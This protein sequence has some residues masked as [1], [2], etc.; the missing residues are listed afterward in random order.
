MTSE[1]NLSPLPQKELDVLLIC[2]NYISEVLITDAIVYPMNLLYLAAYVREKGIEVD[3]LDGRA[4]NYSLADYREYLIRRRPKI[5]G[6]TVMTSYV[7][8]AV[9][10]AELAKSISDDIVVIVG[11]AHISAL[12]AESLKSYGCFDIAVV[13][14]GEQTLLE[15]SRKVLNH[16]FDFSGV[17]GI[18]YRQKGNIKATKPRALF[19]DLDS[20]PYPA[21]DLLP[22]DR[23]RPS[24]QW[25]KKR[26]FL[27]LYTARGCPFQCTFCA[28][29]ANFGRS[30]RLRSPESIVK[31]IEFYKERY[32]IR[33][34]IFYSDTLVINR[35]HINELCDLLMK[36]KTGIVWCCFST[37]EALNLELARKMK[38]AGCFMISF[39]LESGNEDMLR[40][41]KKN[42]QSVKMAKQ[43]IRDVRRA[44][45]TPIG[46]FLLGHPG[47]SEEI[48]EETIQY[49]LD[50]PLSYAAFATVVPFP[51]AP[52]FTYAK[53]KGILP[54]TIT[55]WSGFEEYRDPFVLSEVPKEKLLYYLKLAFRKFYFRPQAILR[56]AQDSL[57][58]YRIWH[59]FFTSI[60]ILRLILQKPHPPAA[61]VHSRS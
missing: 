13:G 45:I 26:P 22:L 41:M 17:D 31:E 15:L 21:Y 43:V 30:V 9:E 51:G 34:I 7:N 49:A 32:G 56:I 44:G 19:P 25:I 2:P 24:I 39:G 57:S 47:D 1:R 38:A 53:E 50:L 27:M 3:I 4:L 48:I 8:Q 11:G 5:V 12:P 58:F 37:V 33:Q 29:K 60:R 46:S 35:K 40:R 36:R 28:S 23:Y 55:D 16:D 59:G 6:I 42:Y 61:K 10:I 20:L 52:I 18:Y 14:E 54:E